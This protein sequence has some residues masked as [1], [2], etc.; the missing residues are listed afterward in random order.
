[1]LLVILSRPLH[2]G[3]IPYLV[4]LVGLLIRFWAAGYI[5]KDARAIE[6]STGCRIIN[7]PYKYLKHPLYIGNFFLVLGVVLLYNPPIWFAGLIIIFFFIEYTLIIL[8]ELHYLKN[9]PE[10]K[11]KFKLANC[12]GEISTI[13][14]VAFIILT[15]Y[16]VPK[17]I[18]T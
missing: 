2:I 13:V 4:I 12:Q 11:V 18:L 9:L 6:F 10:K 15:H 8:S 1:M 17:N 16:T 7:A 14:V 5:G 3:I